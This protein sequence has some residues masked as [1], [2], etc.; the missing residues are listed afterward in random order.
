VNSLDEII[1]AS[2][3]P[4]EV[5]RALSVKMGISGIA[6]AVI[7][8]VLN[9]SVQYVSKWKGIYEAQGAAGLGLGYQGSQGYLTAAQREVVIAWI[10]GHQTLSVEA[11]RDHLEGTYGVVY[12]SKQSYYD[13]LEA[14][15]MSYHQ[16]EKANPKRDEAQVQERREEIKKNWH[17]TGSVSNAER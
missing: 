9:V 2:A 1:N 6:P 17:R 14:G 16:T 12:Q 15:G 5:K 8:Q 10:N 11:L 3:E 4:R 7:S 13:L